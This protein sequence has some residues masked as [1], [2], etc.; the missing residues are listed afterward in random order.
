MDCRMLALALLGLYFAAG[1]FFAY[2]VLSGVL[3]RLNPIYRTNRLRFWMTNA[4]LF[5]RWS[6]GWLPIVLYYWS[7]GRRGIF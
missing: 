7:K 5:V 3:R 6:C 4:I 1:A 2:S